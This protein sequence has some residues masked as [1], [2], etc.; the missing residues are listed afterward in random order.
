MKKSFKL[1]AL[2]AFAVITLSGCSGNKQEKAAESPTEQ[3]EKASDE[4]DA[5]GI[6]ALKDTKTKELTE[7]EL[8]FLFEQ[9]VIIAD[10]EKGMSSKEINEFIEKLPEDQKSAVFIVAMHIMEAYN[11]NLLNNDQMEKYAELEK[12]NK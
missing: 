3:A 11:K 1:I 6:L 10:M 4:I 7:K 2:V 8:D 12:Q 5:E 9:F